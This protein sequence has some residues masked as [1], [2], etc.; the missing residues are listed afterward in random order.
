MGVQCPTDHF[1]NATRKGSKW[2][3]PWETAA[4]VAG[5]GSIELEVISLRF[6][7]QLC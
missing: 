2:S 3:R 7:M 1:V 5:G 6:A 4:A